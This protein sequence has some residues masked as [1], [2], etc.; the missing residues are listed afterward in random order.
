MQR[1]S[2]VAAILGVVFAVN[3]VNA[4]TTRYEIRDLSPEAWDQVVDVMW[5]MKNTTNHTHG[6]ELYGPAFQPYDA[7][8]V[9]H[10]VSSLDMR[11]DQGGPQTARRGHGSHEGTASCINV[12]FS[13]SFFSFSPLLHFSPYN[14]GMYI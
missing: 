8:V 1:S 5:T 6:Q 10:A 9:K 12:S 11:G 13:L 2:V 4:K 14:P 3:A 7:F